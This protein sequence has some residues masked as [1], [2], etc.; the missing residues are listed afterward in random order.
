LELYCVLQESKYIKRL[1]QQ[2]LH[3]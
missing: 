2:L 3:V 1:L